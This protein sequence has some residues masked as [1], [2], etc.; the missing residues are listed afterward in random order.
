MEAGSPVAPAP[1]ITTSAILSQCRAT[2]SA[3]AS[4]APIPARAV[5]PMLANAALT[6]SLLGRF[7]FVSPFF[8][9]ILYSCASQYRLAPRNE[10]VAADFRNR[11]R[12]SLGHDDLQLPPK[13]LDHGFDAFLSE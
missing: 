13:N 2:L 8:P 12:A 3:S 9:M 1:T 6:K 5:A 11:S 7:F 10:R 4:S